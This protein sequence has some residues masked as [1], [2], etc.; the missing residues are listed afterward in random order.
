MARKPRIDKRA[1]N[2]AVK[3]VAKEVDR[4]ARKH[5]AQVPI[6]AVVSAEGG[7]P[8][9]GDDRPEYNPVLARLLLWLDEE[10]R[11]LPQGFADVSKFAEAEGISLADAEVLV[12]QLE[13]R[14][15]V[16]QLSEWGDTCVARISDG[17]RVEARR[18]LRLQQDRAARIAYAAD[19]FLRWLY[20]IAGDSPAD[21]A[22]FLAAPEASFAGAGLSGDDLR[23]ALNHLE[24]HSLVASRDADTIAITTHGTNLVLSGGSVQDHARQSTGAT[25]NNY[26]TN[27]QGVIIGEQQKFT[28]NN[29]ADIDPVPFIQLAGYVGQIN[30]TLELSEPQREELERVAQE[31][32]ATATT[33]TPEPGR[34]RQL[35][36]QIKDALITEGTTIAAQRGIEMAAQAL[37]MLS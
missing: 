21:P 12:S 27:P 35:T 30:S 6:R 17:G 32:H 4:A 31:L 10:L 18:L 11:R 13:Q 7:V 36:S 28:Q 25:Y 3:D 26:L 23:Q 8:M 1:I 2:R 14:S 20:N 15:L 22:L 9:V 33:P 16:K 34:L 29:S 5:P 19:V 37:A 24:E